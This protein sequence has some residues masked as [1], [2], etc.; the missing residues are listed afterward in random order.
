MM[1]AF[2]SS[3]SRDV[4]EMFE[5]RHDNVLRDINGLD[6]SSDLRASWF[7]PVISTDAYG[8]EQPSVD[9]TR[10]GFTLLVMGWTGER[11][12]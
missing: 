7:H 2:R 9:I 8:R 5:K 1:P 11:P 4:A 12:A 6:I 10:Q 3:N